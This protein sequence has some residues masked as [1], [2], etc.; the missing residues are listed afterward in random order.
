MKLLSLKAQG[1]VNGS[2]PL[3][4]RTGIAWYAG[5]RLHC[6]LFSSVANLLLSNTLFFLGL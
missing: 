4:E 1:A 6:W 2:A 3:P 5:S